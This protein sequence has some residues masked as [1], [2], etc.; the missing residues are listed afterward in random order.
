MDQK[1]KIDISELKDSEKAKEIGAFL[2][3][4]LGVKPIVKKKEIKIA[5]PEGSVPRRELKAILKRA[6][7][8][9]GIR[10]E[11]RLLSEAISSF[12]IKKRGD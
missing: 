1:Y 11:F 10:E 5:L 12:K 7:H 2:E 9:A 3:R 8:Y 6:L 4:R